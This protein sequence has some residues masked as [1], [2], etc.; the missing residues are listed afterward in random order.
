MR[1][2]GIWAL[3]QA[4]ADARRWRE[5][6]GGNLRV[7]VN[8]SAPQLRHR[9]FIADIAQLLAGDPAAAAGL[10]L[11]F[12]E[13]ALMV[14]VGHSI[15]SLQTLRSMG[16][17]IAVDDFG[18]GHSSLS[19]LA[20]LPVDTLKIDG[21]FVADMTTGPEGLALASHIIQL[22]HALKVNV[23]AEGVETPEQARLLRLL[24]CET[25]Q[26]FLV[27]DAVPAEVFADNHLHLP[28]DR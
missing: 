20:R 3:G 12:T 11:E 23:M 2:V 19:C 13:S 4:I 21:C 14:D 28:G 18:T 10:A 5:A 22:A 7:A 24:G 1:E 25:M 27:G 26:G 6:G 8:I 17:A 15:A 9:D 16:V